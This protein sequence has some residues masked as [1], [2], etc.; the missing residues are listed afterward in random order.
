ML[1]GSHKALLGATA[2]SF[3]VLLCSSTPNADA[4]RKPVSHTVIIDATSFTPATLTVRAGDSVIWIN[5]DIIPH[6]ATSQ[7]GKFDSGTLL[8]GKSW[9]FKASAKGEFTYGCLFHPTMKGTLR[10]R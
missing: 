5:K 6:T 3:G 7:P 10:V 1:R 4:D 2:V 9:Q 8:T